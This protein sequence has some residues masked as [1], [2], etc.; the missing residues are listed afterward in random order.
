MLLTRMGKR[1]AN[2]TFKLDTPWRLSCRRHRRRGAPSQAPALDVQITLHQARSVPGTQRQA[3]RVERG[4]GAKERYA[5]LSPVVLQ[6]LRAWWKV[7]PA[8]GPMRP[9]GWLFPGHGS[10]GP[11]ARSVQPNGRVEVPGAPQFDH[12]VFARQDR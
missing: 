8:Q 2:Q 7:G 11:A 3:M 9:G 6:H 5:L 12:V 1:H 10:D 4:E